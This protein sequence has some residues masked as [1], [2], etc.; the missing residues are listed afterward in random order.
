MRN[1]VT[2]MRAHDH[3]DTIMHVMLE[4]TTL[5]FERTGEMR[6]FDGQ[7]RVDRD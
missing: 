4:T 6:H 1:V 7:P 5:V 3:T 2:V